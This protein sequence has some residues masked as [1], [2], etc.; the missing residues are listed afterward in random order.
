MA[1]PAEQP[2][3]SSHVESRRAVESPEALRARIDRLIGGF[4]GAAA[5][6]IGIVLFVVA[7]SAFELA[8]PA[9][10]TF[11]AGFLVSQDWDPIHARFGALPFLYGTLVT[12]AVALAL[13]VPVGLGMALFLSDLG[14]S[15]F[16]RPVGTLMTLLAA[17]PS[18]VYGLWAALVLA[19]LLRTTIEPALEAQFG[20]LP[21]FRG[22]SVGVG[23]FCAALVL[24]VMIL[25]T[26]A[27][28]SREVLRAVPWEL[29]EGAL[30]LGATRWDVVRRVVIPHARA[31]LGGAVLLGFGRAASE[32]MAVA[33]VVGSRPEIRG[34]L[35]AP[36]YTMS[37][38]IANEF[39]ESTGT[40]HVAA[41]AEIGLLLFAVTLT[42]NVAARMLVSR[43]RA[44]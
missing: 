32:A 34:S 16:K 25:P 7:L 24:A 33:M 6:A 41:L 18:V 12:S 35:F 43:V 44:T 27:S 39:A 37:S 36:G 4:G 40:L 29:R 38:V 28:V 20:S 21:F 10:R 30:A 8:H 17:V 13:A 5:S 42:V 3:P 15:A 14:P 1:Q 19:P 31:G 23:L 9:I 11:G 22:P 2:S 26:I